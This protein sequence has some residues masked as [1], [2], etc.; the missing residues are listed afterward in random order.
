MLLVVLFDLQPFRQLI[1]VIHICQLHYLG[2]IGWL[3]ACFAKLDQTINKVLLDCT[4][5]TVLLWSI[6][7]KIQL[8][9]FSWST[10]YMYTLN[11]GLSICTQFSLGQTITLIRQQNSWKFWNTFTYKYWP[12]RILLVRGKL[13]KRLRYM[14]LMFNLVTILSLAVT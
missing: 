3:I 14:T 5:W 9:L 10:I 8:G 12:H 7:K 1:Q 11:S 13:D 4:L 2:G 6:D